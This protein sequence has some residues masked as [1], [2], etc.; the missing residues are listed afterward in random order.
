[1]RPAVRL[2][3]LAERNLSDFQPRHHALDV[4]ALCELLRTNAER[5]VQSDYQTNPWSPATAPKLELL[6]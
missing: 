2:F 1:L 5:I 3:H 4:A 6:L